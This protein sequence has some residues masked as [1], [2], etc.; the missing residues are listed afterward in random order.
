MGS[1]EILIGQMVEFLGEL[2][3]DWQSKWDLMR[4]EGQ[5]VANQPNVYHP[6]LILPVNDEEEKYGLQQWLEE[7]YFDSE[8]SVDLTRSEIVKIGALVQRL[9]QF[10]PSSRA[11][12]AEIVEDKLV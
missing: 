4:T 7:V 3:Q 8:K 1:K 5:L 6:K 9:L 11:I 10:D 2:P 12:A